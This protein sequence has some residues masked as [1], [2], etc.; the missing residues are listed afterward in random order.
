MLFRNFSRSEVVGSLAFY[1]FS[2]MTVLAIFS[3]LSMPFSAE[4]TYCING[5]CDR[6]N[7]SLKKYI[8]KLISFQSNYNNR[9]K[10]PQDLGIQKLVPKC[11]FEPKQKAQEMEAKMELKRTSASKKGSVQPAMD[12]VQSILGLDPG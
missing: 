6:R 3:L 10:R 4:W 7:H 9:R 1:L 8:T 11:N 12:L 5:K 2:F